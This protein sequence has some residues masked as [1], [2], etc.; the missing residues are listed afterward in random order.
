MAGVRDRS[1]RKGLEN[2]GSSP[3]V[4]ARGR[5][6]MGFSKIAVRRY[7]IVQMIIATLALRLDPACDARCDLS[8]PI[9]I[10]MFCQ[11]STV[12]FVGEW[13]VVCSSSDR[14]LVGE[15][16]WGGLAEDRPSVLKFGLRTRPEFPVEKSD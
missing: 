4:L 13:R 2:P 1:R 10:E 12:R 5:C 3:G 9:A 6:R 15:R 16:E 8:A 7:R 14:V 11:W